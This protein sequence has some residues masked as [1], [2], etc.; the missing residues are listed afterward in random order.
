MPN[1]IRAT[2]KYTFTT[3]KTSQEFWALSQISQEE[4]FRTTFWILW[5]IIG[6]LSDLLHPR[7]RMMR[8]L[9]SRIWNFIP[10]CVVCREGYEKENVWHQIGVIINLAYSGNWQERETPFARNITLNTAKH[11]AHCQHQRVVPWPFCYLQKDLIL[12]SHKEEYLVAT[13][14]WLLDYEG[15]CPY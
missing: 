1:K 13:L 3:N 12:S 4:F 2:N 8:D 5:D 7:Y 14:H 11:N 9:S 15:S 10:P 6:N